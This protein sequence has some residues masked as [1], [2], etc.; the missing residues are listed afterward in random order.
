MHSVRSDRQ[1]RKALRSLVIKT[2]TF[3]RQ[4][5]EFPVLLASPAHILSGSAFVVPQ[6]FL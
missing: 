2:E 6:E 1:R 5:K 3:L 4:L